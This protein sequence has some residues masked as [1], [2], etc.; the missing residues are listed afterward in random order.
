M[1]EP[2]SSQ[3]DPLKSINKVK[4]SKGNMRNAEEEDKHSFLKEKK[5]KVLL[6]GKPGET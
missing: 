4:G 5:T 3:E 6:K 2:L 1:V